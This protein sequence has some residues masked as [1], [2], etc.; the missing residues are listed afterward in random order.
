M[1][2]TI[3]R[4]IRYAHAAV[5]ELPQGAIFAVRNIEVA[6]LGWNLCGLQRFL[7]KLMR[8]RSVKKT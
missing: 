5:A 7:Q 8:Y 4:P 1:K 2:H 3:A 6:E